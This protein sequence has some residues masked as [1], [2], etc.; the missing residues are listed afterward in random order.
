MMARWLADTAASR[1]AGA[2]QVTNPVND[3]LT[4]LWRLGKPLQWR[5]HVACAR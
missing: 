5:V 2:D 4:W 1:L 3:L